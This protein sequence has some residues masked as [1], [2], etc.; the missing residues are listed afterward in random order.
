MVD[1]DTA[2]MSHSPL[3]MI[4]RASPPPR[5]RPR[6]VRAAFNTITGRGTLSPLFT[7]ATPITLRLRW[8]ILPN[9]ALPL[10]L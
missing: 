4:V 10:P 1:D 8:L 9:T 6:A 7:T 5:R 3:P 2:T